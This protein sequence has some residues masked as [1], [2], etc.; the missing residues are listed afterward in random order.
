M[1]QENIDVI[2][3]TTRAHNEGDIEG[4]V[5]VTHPEIEM[6]LIGGF[7]DIA[8]GS[9]FSGHAG[10][11]RFFTDWFATFETVRLDHEKFIEAG[12]NI[13]SVSKLKATVA[14]SPA[15]VELLFGIV[16]GFKEGKVVQYDGYYELRE[17]FEAV[18]LSEQE[19]AHRARRE[20]APTD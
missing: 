16:W 7:A 19:G 15:P 2:Q 11:R 12:E 18:G 5:E 14:G 10:V 8:G 17:A 13:V 4:I 20:G 6:K 9:S 1:S 3:R